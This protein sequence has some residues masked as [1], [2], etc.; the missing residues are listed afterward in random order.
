[1]DAEP[2]SQPPPTSSGPALPVPPPAVVASGRVHEPRPKSAPPPFS[3]V[4]LVITFVGQCIAGLVAGM[5]TVT[6]SSKLGLAP[7]R[8]LA[9]AGTIAIL[10]A[11]SAGFLAAAVR[12]KV[13]TWE[14]L[15]AGVVFC[16]LTTWQLGT[17]LRSPFGLYRPVLADLGYLANMFGQNPMGGVGIATV[18]IFF[19]TF[20]GGSLGCLL[21]GS[22]KLDLRF[23]YEAFIARSHLRLRKHSA[24][25]IMTGITVAGVALG[26]FA[27]T[28]VLSV[29][30][31]F[32]LDLK[33]KIIGTNAHAVVLKYGND[34]KEWREAADKVR[35]VPGV[36]GATPFI[37]NEVMVSSD[38]NISGA[39]VKGIDPKSVAQVTNLDANTKEGSLEWLDHP[40][41]ITEPEGAARLKRLSPSDDAGGGGEKAGPRDEDKP[42]T[43]D[44]IMAPKRPAADGKAEKKDGAP[45]VA[46]PGILIGKELAHSLKVMVGDRINV[47]SPLGGELGPTGPMPKSRPF[48]VAGIFVT[49]MYEYDAKFAYISLAEAQTFFNIPDSVTGLEVKTS[50]ID[51]TRQITR[52]ILA[53]LDGYPYRTKDWGEMNKNLFSAL[54]LEK[55]VM[56][57]LL[58]LFVLVACF[59]ILS[60]LIM[61]VLE[62]RKEIS[63]L[64]SMGA[65]DTSV[66]KVFVLEGLIIGII[67]TAIGLVLGYFACLLVDMGII[68]LDAEVYYIDKLPVKI[69]ALQFAIVALIAVTMSYLSTIY[70]ATRASRVAPVDGLRNE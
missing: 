54:R 14:I 8:A 31:G 35:K 7:E 59:G 69:D 41:K 46:T 51:D 42:L 11:G 61:M 63:I 20:L 1:M 10:A 49:G 66:M 68:Q 44:E 39:L 17:A 52:A 56:A 48:R 34:F 4:V 37:L 65:T 43:P 67:G 40:E 53:A 36:V 25:R 9:V 22:G 57:V 21:A 23:S 47:I 38:Q 2:R 12:R 32:E 62:K 58:G 64:K 24:T 27:L 18:A 13:G 19:A 15:T 33:S 50:D 70:P 30:S 26:V 60:T 3:M 16:S 55:L 6:L 45:A 28:V 5:G 29:M